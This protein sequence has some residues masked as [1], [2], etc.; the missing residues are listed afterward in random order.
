MTG[1]PRACQVAT[2][3]LKLLTPTI[4][5][6]IRDMGNYCV[7]KYTELMKEIP[8][9]IIRVNGTGLLYQVKLDPKFEVTAMDGVEMT[10]RRRGVNVIHGGTNALRFTPNFDITKEEVDLHVSHVREVLLEKLGK[11]PQSKL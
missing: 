3:S 9:A 2:A 8:E 4:R 5:A 10:L 7:Q 6:N 11:A 1:N